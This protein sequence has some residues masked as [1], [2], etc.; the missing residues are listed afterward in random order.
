MSAD[1]SSILRRLTLIENDLTPVSVKK[2]L[3][4]QQKSAEQVPALFKP[5]QIHALKDKT[6]PKHPMDGKLVGESSLEKTMNNVEENMLDKVRKDLNSY[7][8]ALKK[9]TK[10][11]HDLVD[12]AKD[13][14]DA[15][16]DV[17]DEDPTESEPPDDYKPDPVTDPVMPES[18]VTVVAMEDGKSCEVYGD[19]DRGFEVGHNG[20]RM[21]TKFNTLDEATMAIEMYKKRCATE[22]TN[23]D[24]IDEA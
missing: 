11:D 18:A 8:D 19:K 24:Y 20:R 23:P 14:M 1:I 21:K 4:T 6:D 5:K 7:L 17:I 12:K 3:N 15:N 22:S 16:E 10:I 2:G 13:A 9:D